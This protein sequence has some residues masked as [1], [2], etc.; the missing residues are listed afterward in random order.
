[1][2]NEYEVYFN[3][4]LEGLYD[5]IA[6]WK[7]LLSGKREESSRLEAGS[8]PH[9]RF[10]LEDE[11][12]D[13]KN[14]IIKF[15]DIG[16]G[17]FSRC[18]LKT[19]RVKLEVLAVDPLADAYK[20]LKKEYDVDN[21]IRLE[22]GFVEL[23]DKKFEK[24]TFDIVHMSNSLDHCFDALFGIYQL[25]NI[26]KIGGKVILRHHE[27]EAERNGNK[28]FHQWNLSLHNEES[29]FIIWRDDKRYDICKL[30]SDY[31]DIMLYPDVIEE[32]SGWTYNKVVMIKKK[33]VMIPPNEYANIILENV[34]SF[35]IGTLY[36]NAMI[37]TGNKRR[38]YN[39]ILCDKIDKIDINL[40]RKRLG[41]SKVII[42]GIGQVG[43]KLFDVLATNN[44]EIIGIVDRRK[45]IYKGYQSFSVNDLVEI[46]KEIPIVVTVS[47]D[48]EQIKDNLH[49]YGWKNIKNINEVTK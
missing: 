12:P 10:T 28:G 29:S 48:Y 16:S 3:K 24:N 40:L 35:L 43:Q 34:Y 42:Y 38:I 4:W 8:D 17:A 30:F 47:Y 26:C 45:E 7:A 14:R 9:K 15:V 44:I 1:M 6:Y 22:T 20:L 33:D 37:E 41:G 25:L 32:K 2:T 36:D 27:N 21:G 31:A 46:D 39:K 23:L 19:D 13:D 5:E 18:G 49:A 11:L